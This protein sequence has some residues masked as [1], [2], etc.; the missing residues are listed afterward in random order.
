M[1]R[2]Q[3][4]RLALMDTNKSRE[5]VGV[6]ENSAGDNFRRTEVPHQE[7][8]DPFT[9]G[10]LNVADGVD[11]IIGKVADRSMATREKRVR[12]SALKP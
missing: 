11:D 3:R 12:G 7:G 9:I 2:E 1:I 6:M 8:P 4:T 5:L 10:R